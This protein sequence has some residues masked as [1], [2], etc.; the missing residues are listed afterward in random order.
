MI[1]QAKFER[2]SIL[3][4]PLL[5]GFVWGMSSQAES[6][7]GR[8]SKNIPGKPS[9]T[10][11]TSG[12]STPQSIAASVDELILKELAKSEVKPASRCLDEDF[13][14]RASLD[15]TGRLPS[16]RDVT[17]FVLDPDSTKRQ[18][19]IDQLIDSPDFGKNWARYW[20]DVIYM[21]ATEMRSR[22]SQADFEKWM[23]D[24][25]NGNTGWDKT[26]TSM[27]TAE[28][29][30]KEHPETALIFAQGGETEDIAAEACRIFLGIQM[31]CANC[32]D[33]PSD[34]WKREQFHAVAAFFPRIDLRRMNDGPLTVEVR[35]VDSDR[36]RGELMRE[37]PERFI[38]FLDRNR[39]Q[40]VSK[41]EMKMGR[42]RMKRE[43]SEVPVPKMIERIFEVADSNKDGVITAAEVKAIPKQMKSGR[44][45][46]EHFMPDL[47][48]P[49]S[50]GKMI[51]PKFFIGELSPGHGLN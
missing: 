24:Q 9:S 6:A 14:R 49:S 47:K 2:Q 28:G 7:D 22:L 37:N 44:G 3:T 23:G 15:I 34:I 18:Q 17:F 31:Q 12:T 51:E 32:H 42:R 5:L 26:V 25:W 41:E 45:S 1:R 40:K 4:L 11:S 36:G 27:L 8:L 29:D 33:H 21:P 38:A 13:L 48:D 16:P 50:K 19:R 10:S 43:D 46:T 30:V 20:R 35:S 39:D